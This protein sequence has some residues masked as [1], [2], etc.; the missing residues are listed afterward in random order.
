MGKI[1]WLA[2]VLLGMMLAACGP[3]EEQR[4]PDAPM[5]Q[6]GNP[7]SDGN[8]APVAPEGGG[9]GDGT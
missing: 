3:D 9:T 7:A 6:P 8:D 4:P 5:M 1:R 2:V